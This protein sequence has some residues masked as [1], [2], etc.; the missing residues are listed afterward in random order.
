MIDGL[1]V[2]S[3]S[4]E[5]GMRRQ[6]V[7]ERGG[8]LVVAT[9][10]FESAAASHDGRGTQGSRAR[11]SEAGHDDEVGGLRHALGILPFGNGGRLLARGS[12]SLGGAVVFPGGTF[13]LRLGHRDSSL[14]APIG[15]IAA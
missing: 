15:S 14:P 12:G 2:T 4:K 8:N 10:A 7:Y 11:R 5:H 1:A 6:G 13:V 9:R 3:C